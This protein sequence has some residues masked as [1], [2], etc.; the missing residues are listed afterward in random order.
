MERRLILPV[1]CRSCDAIFDLWEE[2]SKHR[3]GSTL[4]KAF[5]QGKH[6]KSFICPMCR[7]VEKSYIADDYSVV[8]S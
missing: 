7:A 5:A 2:I 6:E 1:Q 4:R 8:Y 3:R